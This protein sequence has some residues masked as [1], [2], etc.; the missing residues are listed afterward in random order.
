M[1]IGSEQ[2]I[3]DILDMIRTQALGMWR[4]RWHSVVTAWLVC[5]LGWFFVYVMP[6]TYQAS[7]RVYVDTENAIREFLG[8]IATAT[9]VTNQ[10]TVVVREIVS[11][12]NLA[13]V[14]RTTDLSL[15]AN[16]DEQFE[17]LLTALQERIAVVGGRDGVYSISYVDPDRNKALAVVDALLNAFIEKSLGADRSGSRQAQQFLQ[18]QIQEYEQRLT[19][20]EN[21]LADFKRENVEFMPDQQGDYFSRLQMGESELQKTISE[22]NLASERRAELLRQIEGEEPVFGIMGSSSSTTVSTG[23][24]SAKIRELEAQLKELRLQ[25]TDKHPRIGQI[26]E[27]IEM[28][29]Q[30]EAAGAERSSTPS[31]TVPP[32]PLDVNPV[33]QSMRIQLSNVEVELAALREERRQQQEEVVRLRLLVDTIPQVEAEL[34]RLNRDYDVVKAKHQQLLQQLEMANIGEDVSQS[35]DGVQFRIIDPPFAEDQPTG[36]NRPA[37]LAGVLIVGLGIGL[38]VAFLMNQLRPTFIGNRSVTEVLGI[39]VL[40]SISL[41]QSAAERAAERKDRF[42]LVAASLLLFVCFALAVV[43]APTGSG[44]VRLLV[45]SVA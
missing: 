10:V 26:L 17:S 25:Y 30:Q 42:G 12:P 11:R 38:G 16:T 19:A 22:M 32:K 24:N 29:E 36:P 37:F 35:I 33:Y 41:L 39:P 3:R 23:F 27:T 20:A 7:A 4:F 45:A 31:P 28:L 14:A 6:D 8:G 9:D 34:N 2:I 15:R 13:E 43:F 44:L 18:D 21:R 1:A 5:V 40:A